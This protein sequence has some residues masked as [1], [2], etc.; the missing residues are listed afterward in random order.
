V[1]FVAPTTIPPPAA[2]WTLDDLEPIGPAAALPAHPDP[3]PQPSVHQPAAHQPSVHQPAVH[4]PAVHQAAVRQAAEPRPA[5]QQPVAGVP[6]HGA[7]D[8]A[9]LAAFLRGAGLGEIGGTDP[10]AMMESVGAVLRTMVDRMREIQADRGS[11]KREFRILATMVN[12]EDNNPIKFSASNEAALRSLLTGKRPADRA[13]GEVLDEIRLHEVAMIAA[14]R[15]AVSGLLQELN[16]A[17]LLAAGHAFLPGQ[18]KAKAF[19][20]YEALH[21]RVVQALTDDFDSVFGKAFARAYERVALDE[22]KPSA[23]TR[24]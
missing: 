6:S 17:P 21:A 14:M 11:I 20:Q 15:D 4:Q 24:K 19:E 1:P 9:L 22:D 2:E 8:A 5:L 23:R 10:V 12:P 16:P 3:A 13:V 18:R 7:G